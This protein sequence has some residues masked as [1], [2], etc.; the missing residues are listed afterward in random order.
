MSSPCSQLSFALLLLAGCTPW[1]TERS[2][3]PESPQAR[4]E[5]PEES[6]RRVHGR[7]AGQ[8]PIVHH[9]VGFDLP[10]MMSSE[11]GRRGYLELAELATDT[12]TRSGNDGTNLGSGGDGRCHCVLALEIAAEW[13]R[14]RCDV[15]FNLDGKSVGE[16]HDFVWGGD[17]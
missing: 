17:E 14:R 10:E 6:P 1:T 4:P 3:L 5:P 7:R 12:C 2:T 9:S 16:A 13:E 11:T 8:M 15:F